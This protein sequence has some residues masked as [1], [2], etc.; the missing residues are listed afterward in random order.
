MHVCNIKLKLRS[1]AQ[2][3]TYESGTT[4]IPSVSPLPLGWT[5][6]GPGRS[7]YG[8]AGFGGFGTS[9]LNALRTGNSQHGK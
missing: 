1:L 2:L 9:A 5:R 3:Q 7:S 6:P 8:E 4:V